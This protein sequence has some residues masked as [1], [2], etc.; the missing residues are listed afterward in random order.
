[1]QLVRRDRPGSR[2]AGGGARA[3]A[4]HFADERQTHDRG[5]GSALEQK[6]DAYTGRGAPTPDVVFLV[7]DAKLRAG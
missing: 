7:L 6:A 3:F 2:D 1:M 5:L 4:G